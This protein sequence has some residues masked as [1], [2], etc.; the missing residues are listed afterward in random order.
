[1]CDPNGSSSHVFC[2]DCANT[3]GL[4]G[5]NPDKTRACPACRTELT[6]PDDAVITNLHPTE[7]YKTSVLSGLSPDIIMECASRALGFWTYQ[8]A[9]ETFVYLSYEPPMTSPISADQGAACSVYH[10]YLAKTWSEKFAKVQ[11][12]LDSFVNE[13]NSQF[14]GLEEKLRSKSSPYPVPAGAANLRRSFLR[15]G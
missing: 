12:H 3:Q 7:D 1:M 11:I 9:Q 15:Q 6:N 13:A 2:L 4:T 5:H 8:T 10:Q 14:A